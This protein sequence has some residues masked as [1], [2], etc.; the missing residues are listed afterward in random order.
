[1]LPTTGGH[2][3]DAQFDRVLSIAIHPELRPAV[4][5]HRLREH[6]RD[7][8]LSGN[9]AILTNLSRESGVWKYRHRPGV[10]DDRH[11]VDVVPVSDLGER[12]RIT[13]NVPE[14]VSI[15]VH[16]AERAITL[17][18]HPGHLHPLDVIWNVDSIWSIF[19]DRRDANQTCF[20]QSHTTGEGC[21]PD[22]SSAS[23][24]Q[25]TS[26]YV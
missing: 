21:R 20:E 14:S 26:I 17:G 13:V 12:D 25:R 16:K 18:G 11:Q 15:A 6:R 23:L 2:R 8:L 22:E 9:Q 5:A 3:A 1:M 19:R 7:S 4:K 24:Q 10:P